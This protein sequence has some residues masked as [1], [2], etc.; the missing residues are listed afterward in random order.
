MNWSRQASIPKV[1]R[2][3]AP[4]NWP[5]SSSARSTISGHRICRAGLELAH[6]RWRP[7]VRCPE[8]IPCWSWLAEAGA[9]VS[10]G[11][12]PRWRRRLSAHRRTLPGSAFRASRS[13]RCAACAASP[14]EARRP[15]P[16]FGF[17]GSSKPLRMPFSW[18]IAAAVSGWRIRWRGPCSVARRE[19]LAGKLGRGSG[20]RALSGRVCRPAWSAIRLNR[21]AS[22]WAPA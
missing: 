4:P 10:D 2:S 21:L 1:K 11:L 15:A 17:V 7:C 13:W 9:R 6:R 14:P 22:R 19:E 16:I 20:T 5:R 12:R 18:S 3:P 8:P